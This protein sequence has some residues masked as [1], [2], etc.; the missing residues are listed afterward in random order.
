MRR[1]LIGVVLGYLLLLLGGPLVAICTEAFGGGVGSLWSA[2][3][4][5]DVLHAFGMTLG[6]A[7]AAV[8]VCTVFGTLVAFVLV[9]HRFPGR[10]FFNG[11]V[12][13]PFAVS[14][15]VAGLMF[16]LLFGRGGWLEAWAEASGI[17]MIF[18]WPGMLLAT[19]FVA[20]PFVI[21]EVM[22]VLQAIGI[23]QEQAAYTLGASRW[24]TF[25]RVTLPSVK[26]GLLY[27][28]TLTFARAMGEFGAVLIVSGGISGRTETATLFIFRALDERMQAA[29]MGAALV[30]AS[31]SF[32]ILIAM[33]L[34]KHHL[35]ED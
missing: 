7:S 23:D 6:I 9:R 8:L 1:L 18:N 34:L 31:L 30:M 12:D 3:T 35:Q 24:T 16:I 20:L 15:V 33:E 32:M 26:W 17:K 29:A 2:L 10:A 27:G 14:P 21:R 28:I 13:M 22:P 11:L 5:P 25:R 19:I 4:E